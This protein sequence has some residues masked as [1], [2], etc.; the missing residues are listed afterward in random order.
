MFPRQNHILK[1]PEPFPSVL[2]GWSRTAIGSLSTKAYLSVSYISHLRRQYAPFCRVVDSCGVL[3]R[4]QYQAGG[5][6][7]AY[8]LPWMSAYMTIHNITGFVLV[9][10]SICEA[11]NTLLI[12]IHVSGYAEEMRVIICM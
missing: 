8:R 4:V 6:K 1:I 5:R 12:Q 3:F 9:G 7:L 11:D 2:R 10:P